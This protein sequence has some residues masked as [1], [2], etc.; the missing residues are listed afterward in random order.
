MQTKDTNKSL[1][2]RVNPSALMAMEQGAS[3]SLRERSMTSWSL[4]SSISLSATTQK[5][6]MILALVAAL[7]V[8]LAA[9]L[10]VAQRPVPFPIA[11]A[12][13][14]RKSTG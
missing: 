2:S 9:A 13:M 3:S 8:A 14:I 10:V 7:A 5:S 12:M 1:S 11:E 6:L 4:F